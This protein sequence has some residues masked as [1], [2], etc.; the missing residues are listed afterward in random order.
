MRNLLLAA[1]LAIFA[2]MTV[3]PAKA[4]A[5]EGSG[6]TFV[7]PL[8]KAASKAYREN[9]ADGT[10][11]APGENEIDYEPVGSLGGILRLQQIDIDFAAI[12]FPLPRAELAKFGYVQFPIVVGAIAPVVNIGALKDNPLNLP[13]EVLAEIYLGKIQNWNDPAIAAANPG[14]ALPDLRIAVVHRS[15]GS[16]TTYNWT[17][18]LSGVSPEWKEKYGADTLIN[19]PLGSGAEGGGKL[20]EKV[21]GTDGAIGY[22]EFGQASRAGLALARVG[23]GAQAFAAPDAASI[24]AAATGAQ[25]SSANDFNISLIGNAAPGGY[26]IAAAV[27]VI[28]RA[29]GGFGNDNTRTLRFFQ[30]LLEKGPAIA[31]ELGYVPLPESTVTEVKKHWASKFDYG[32]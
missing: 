23:M 13:G 22:L 3:A 18:Y 19:W 20:A 25:W 17:R 26:P 6:S 32:S 27:Y 4:D 30:F 24:A 15:D 14:I 29:D 10:D 2:L 5:V 21:K 31:S 1:M 16:G 8:I 7:F 28:M 9:L 12:D 11:Y